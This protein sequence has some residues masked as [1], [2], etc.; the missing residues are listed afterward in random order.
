M[1][2]RLLP[3][4][5]LLLLTAGS[6]E[7]MPAEMQLD[8]LT[9]KDE[10][11]G[12]I[13]V[14][15]E[16]YEEHP[17]S[18]L[19]VNGKTYNTDAP[20]ELSEAGFYTLE[21]AYT[22]GDTRVSKT[23]RIVILDQERG[24]AEW[25]LHKWTPKTATYQ[26][27]P[28]I[29]T[30]IRPS[31]YPAGVKIPVVFIA[32]D[33]ITLERTNLHV[34]AGATSFNIKNGI[35]AWLF[36]PE[37]LHGPLQI[38]EQGGFEITSNASG[39]EPEKLL[40]TLTGDSVILDKTFYR[41]TGDLTIPAQTTLMI[42][43][44]SFITVDPGVN[45]YNHG[46][47]IVNGTQA[48]PVTI[49]CSDPEKYWG[50]MISTEEGNAI[51][52]CH[53]MICQSGYHTGDNYD[54]GHAKRQALFYM[55]NGHLSLEHCYMTDHAGQI[56]YPVNSSVE[57]TGCLVQRAKTGGQIN[58]SE[59][60]IR[61]SVFTDFPDDGPG[62][63]DED[64][65][66]LY[67]M[68]SNAVIDHSIFMYAKDDGLDSGGSEGGSIKVTGCHFEAVFHEGAALSSGG[69]VSKSHTFSKCT[70]KN[71]EQGLE[72]GYSSPNHQVTVDSCHFTG[73]SVGIRY[74]DNYTNQ[75][76]GSMTITNS[77]SINNDDKDVWNMVRTNWSADTAKMQFN[78]VTVSQFY[79]VYPELKIY[80]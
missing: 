46:Q 9:D 52:A 49:T 3:Y 25:G 15:V 28:G 40:G 63:L 80:E 43:S 60:H 18:G 5:V 22:T 65:D 8:E 4:I 55:E 48:K 61:N 53:T 62:Y 77:F 79:E 20:L 54:Y 33:G 35:G 57:I 39:Q 11:T 41:V 27:Q 1:I 26:K 45:I 21:V 6:C 56:F 17:V 74:G 32:G 67:I 76:E 59:L 70:F 72:L 78:N 14:S 10:Y 64:N 7:K 47:L 69:N 71:C 16:E 30:M 31:E 75:H 51:F 68:G 2:Q 38:G 23:I 50:G 37:A 12:G 36:S 58:Q 13:I 44:G 66:A 34:K 24:V 19:L 29:I 73:N 42:R